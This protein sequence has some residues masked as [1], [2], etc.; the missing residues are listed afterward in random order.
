M[1]SASKCIYTH[2]HI[3]IA[4]ITHLD[5]SKQF[6]GIVHDKSVHVIRYATVFVQGPMVTNGSWVLCG[7]SP[8]HLLQGLW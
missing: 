1:L 4:G 7:A 6:H 3:I 2:N 8:V 5:I